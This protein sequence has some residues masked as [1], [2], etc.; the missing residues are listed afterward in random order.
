M[1]A[2]KT[3]VALERVRKYARESAA[4]SLRLASSSVAEIH[5]R[6]HG[7]VY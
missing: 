6:T 5:D 4:A 7:R 2:T 3:Q 1:A